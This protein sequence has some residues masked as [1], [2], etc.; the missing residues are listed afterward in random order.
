MTRIFVL[1]PLFEL[2]TTQGVELGTEIDFYYVYIVP[3]YVVPAIHGPHLCWEE[4][5]LTDVHRMAWNH[6]QSDEG[7]GNV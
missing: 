1:Y 2:V 7:H 5:K 3:H 4:W 6:L